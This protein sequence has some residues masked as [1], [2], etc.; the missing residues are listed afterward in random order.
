M[1]MWIYTLFRKFGLFNSL[2][3]DKMAQELA[4]ISSQLREL[5]SCEIGYSMLNGMCIVFY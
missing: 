4:Y 2:A 5:A 1:I 3:L